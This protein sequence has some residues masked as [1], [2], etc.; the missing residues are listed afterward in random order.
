MSGPVN[1]VVTW[2]RTQAAS[3]A[4]R[5]VVT[6]GN[7]L[8]PCDRPR[9]DVAAEEDLADLGEGME[10]VDVVCEVRHVRDRRAAGPHSH[11]LDVGPFALGDLVELGEVVIAGREPVARRAPGAVVDVELTQRVGARP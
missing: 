4:T 6:D 5:I 9:R 10:V 1:A 3:A 2:S 8:A 11:R 7:L